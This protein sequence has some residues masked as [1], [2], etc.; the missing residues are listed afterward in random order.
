MAFSQKIVDLKQ[1]VLAKSQELFARVDG[2]LKEVARD[3][4]S[5]KE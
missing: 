4:L 3:T 2:K 5:W 1:E